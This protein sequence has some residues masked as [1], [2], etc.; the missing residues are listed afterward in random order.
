MVIVEVCQGPNCRGGGASLLEIEELVQEK[1]SHDKNVELF[2]VEGGCRDYCSVGPNVHIRHEKHG[3]IE[4]ANHVID[5][6]KCEEVVQKAK[7][8]EARIGSDEKMTPVQAGQPISSNS[9]E[10]SHQSMMA[11]R[12]ARIRWETLR[13][14]SR[15]LSK[16]NKDVNNDPDILGDHERCKR[17]IKLLTEEI[18]NALDKSFDAEISAAKGSTERDRAARRRERLGRN[19]ITRLEIC[20]E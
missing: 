18:L 20:F 12:A 1:Q 16:C 6:S 5:P 14:I 11:R 15:K 3:Y 2:L 17:K 8:L 19:I 7:D 13:N 10:G 4:S 9:L